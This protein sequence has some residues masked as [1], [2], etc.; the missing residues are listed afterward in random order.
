LD[1]SIL[2]LRTKSFRDFI[3]AGKQPISITLSFFLLYRI[4]RKED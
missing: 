4:K 3:D 2:S 1:F